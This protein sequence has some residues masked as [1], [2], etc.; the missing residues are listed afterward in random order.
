MHRAAKKDSKET[1][2]SGKGV[3]RDRRPTARWL[4][5]ALEQEFPDE[6]RHTGVFAAGLFVLILA[7]YVRTM[8][9]SVSGGDNGELLGCACELGIAH[10]PG[11]PTF[12]MVGHLFFKFFP[13]G[14]PAFRIAFMSA[15][16]DALA[17]VLV[18]LSLQRWVLMHTWNARRD[19]RRLG[20]PDAAEGKAAAAKSSD[21]AGLHE[22]AYIGSKWVGILGGGL[23]SLSPLVWLYSLQAEV[24]ALNNMF[25]ALLLYLIIRYNEQRSTALAYMGAFCIG[26]GLTNQH[27][28]IL[29]AV[30][31]VVWAL[32]QDSFAL[33][34]AR[35]FSTMVALGLLGLSPYVFLWTHA[36]HSPLGSWGDTGTMEGFI[37]HFTRK[38][39]G[40]FQ[41][42]SGSDGQSASMLK[43]NFLYVKSLTDDG[44]GVGVVLLIVGLLHAIKLRVVAQQETPATPI[45][46]AWV[47][48][49]VVFHSL[50]N[51]PIDK[52]KLFLGIHMRFWM[53]PHLISFMLIGLGFQAV[54]SHPRLLKGGL[55][56]PV[57]GPG[58]VVAMIGAQIGLNFAKL[59]QSNNYHIA[60]LGK[61]H[62]Q[63]L[64]KSAIVIS[65]GDM[66]TNSMRYLQ[67]CEKYRRDV[68]LLDET[69]MT[70][71]W[72]RDAQ[73]PKM[74]EWGIVFPNHY[75]AP[76]GYWQSDTYSMEQFLA[77]NAKNFKKHP[78]F[79]AGAW[80]GDVAGH[81]DSGVPSWHIVPVGLVAKVY[82][83]G[84][85]MSAKDFLKWFQKDLFPKEPDWFGLGSDEFAW[86]WLM[87]RIVLEWRSKVAFRYANIAVEKACFRPPVHLDRPFCA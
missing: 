65:Q 19:R 70:Y 37:T 53:Q 47:F 63:Y 85:D 62:L 86:E 6:F 51:L 20:K 24:F 32:C 28:L 26:L 44:L 77:A 46:S 57:I 80:L 55:W 4:P 73:G 9:P 71:K 49:L 45:I 39:Y 5:V 33:C 78:L 43:S 68:L 22:S 83:K 35:H 48:Y 17:G 16:C 11:Y 64:P 41:L 23:Y 42:Y 87:R 58:L 81:K 66:I 38:E 69:M 12:T 52:L 40:T 15:A 14:K 79:K 72:M 76:P 2:G 31:L 60:E 3:G 1:G 74:A 36:Y 34:S 56:Q 8:H 54:L 21:T 7:V 50:S 10:P 59:D 84:K 67:R 29:Y 18:M 13:F 82:R 25:N 75:H 30:P 27:T 61:K